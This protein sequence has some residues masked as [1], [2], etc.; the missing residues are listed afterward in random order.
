M[1]NVPDWVQVVVLGLSYLA[2]G[3][4]SV[5]GLR[6]NRATLA[7]VSAAVLIALGTLSLYQA[8]QAIDADTIVFLLSM[9][10]VNAYLSYAGFF[11]L[12]L[13]YLLRLTRSPL[14][15]LGLLTVGTGALSALFLNDTLALVST[16]LTVQLTRS[17]KLN[18]VPYLLA[19]AGATNIGS[20][21]TLS[22]NPQ[23][24]LVGSFSG[25]SYSE[26]ALTLTPV[27]I[28][29]LGLQIGLLWLLY[30]EVRSLRP[31]PPY[32]LPH[33][34]VYRPVLIKTLIV[35]SLLLIA[36][37]A[38]LPLAESAFLAAAALLVTRRIKP[39]RV[40]QQVDWSLLVMFSGLFV[41]T[42]CVQELDLLAGVATW[43]AHPAGLLAV[44]AIVSN[45]ISNVPAV[46][47]LQGM[48]SPDATQSWL[49]L[50]AGATLAGNLTLFGAV[51][52]LI[53]VEAAAAA[54]YRLSFWQ[55]LQFGLPLTLMTLGLTY[56]WI[57]LR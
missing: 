17:L 5:P 32:P 49:L 1:I 46:L 26:F 23:N 41:L 29:G 53:T 52:N 36:F 25:I 55:H 40:L 43:V 10:V 47:L 8:W 12:A 9:M 2:L 38:G 15:L 33:F 56:A 7:L 45:L 35:T 18:P 54:G 48:I 11:K 30:P 19:I 14:G 27:A 16:P 39:Q 57:G 6:M 24:I 50:A 51:A 4:G 34:R 28:I 42:R 44:T 21:A 22:G 37:G 31:C 13:L 20:V 3:I